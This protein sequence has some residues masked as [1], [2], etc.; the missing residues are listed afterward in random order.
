VIVESADGTIEPLADT[1]VPVPEIKG[2]RFSS[3]AELLAQGVKSGDEG[4]D[5]VKE[6]QQM[7][8]GL[9]STDPQTVGGDFG[10]P[11]GNFGPMTEA[12]VKKMQRAAGLKGDG[13]VGPVTKA[14]LTKV[15]TND[16]PIDGSRLQA[17]QARP[18]SWTID[19]DSVPAQLPKDKVTAEMGAAFAA[20]AT[21]GGLNF[22]QA[23]AGTS[24]D[25]TIS[26]AIQP[27]DD[28]KFDGPGGELARATSS[29]ITFDKDERWELEGAPHP[30]RKFMDWD[31]MYFRLLP[32]AIHEIGH[33]LGLGHSS[34]PIDVMSPYYLPDRIVVSEN[35]VAR[36]NELLSTQ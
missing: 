36:L 6:L 13:I 31:E 18:I 2:P 15:M 32:V 28:H 19:F 4:D 14:R 17:S 1:P 5:D 8:M 22:V 12:A 21:A 9:D 24:A 26:W 20:W 35:D 23:D 10:V 33:V 25:V 34:N 16:Q 3:M 27:G 7:L 30:Q 29:S 11:D